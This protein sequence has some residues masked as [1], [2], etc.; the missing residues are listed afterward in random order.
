M[1]TAL[2]TMVKILKLERDQGG[3]DTAVMGGLGA[4][5]AGWE[6][7]ARQQARNPMHHILL[8]EIVDSL[9]NYASLDEDKSRLARVTYLLDRIHN[10]AQPP[11]KYRERLAR[12]SARLG[13][14]E[15][16]GSGRPDRRGEG[17]HNDRRQAKTSRGRRDRLPGKPAFGDED[18]TWENDYRSA[19]AV[20]ELDL[21]P[22]PSLERPPRLPRKDWSL[23]EAQDMTKR[24][25]APTTNVRGIGPKLSATLENLGLRTVGD[26]LRYFPRAYHD[27][28]SFT[29]IRDL[30]AGED[31]NVIATVRSCAVVAGA[32]GREDFVATVSDGSGALAL[33]FF[34]GGW[35]EYKLRRGMQIELH[36]RTSIYRDRLQMTNPKWDELDL[37]N[38][39]RRGLTPVYRLTEGLRERS[40]RNIMKSLS[41]D[42]MENMPD[43]LPLEAL[44]RADL[45]D[46]GWALR[47][48]HFP[49]GWDH[50][51]HARRRLRFDE[52]VLLQ[53]A[54]LTKRKQWQSVTGNPL[55]VDDDALEAFIGGAFDFELTSAQKKAI[56][57]IRADMAQGIPMSRLLQGDVGSGKTAVAFVA[58]ALALFNAKQ[59]A[60]MAPTGI[61]AE[62]H[63]AKMR[64]AFAD[65]PGERQPVIALLTGA[66]STTERESIYRRIADGSIDLVVGTH[67]LIQESLEFHDLG[68]AV[69]DEQQRF[70]VEQRASLRGKGRNPHLLIMTATPI[71]RTLAQTI[72]ADLDLTLIDEMPPGRSPVITR[73]FD[74]IARERMHGFVLGQIEA[75]RQVFFA[76]PLVEESESIATASAE[77]AHIRLRKVFHRHR[78]CLLHGRMTATEKDD[79]MDAFRRGD[80]DVMVTT[81]VTEVGVDVPN[82][83][84]MVVD[85]ANRFG[86]AQLHQFRGRVGR[87]EHQSHCFLIPDKSENISVDRV[88]DALDGVLP[89]DALSIAEQRLAAMA[90]TNDGFE[91]AELDWKLRGGGDILG[92]KQSGAN[93]SEALQMAA[94]DLVEL[95]QRE[96]RTL[97][98]EDPD[99]SATAHRLLKARVEAKY[100]SKTVL[101]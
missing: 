1:P 88:L 94:P 86:L 75:G 8:D 17:R 29:C 45:A 66:L 54:M 28:T 89:N 71:P 64:E 56:A 96:A 42:W 30:V 14:A 25:D 63:Y 33:R 100:P 4:F 57:A 10:R 6:A 43:P 80:Y 67:A 23:Q 97:F 19:S 2:E 22:L 60:L 99:L 87:G 21:R 51:T 58:L 68:V 49:D 52:L 92:S 47:Q 69:I 44:E 16:R 53:L 46:L 77:E 73:I 72:H 3:R 85:G 82:A 13:D 74:P 31:A 76:H 62:Q 70:G 9:A 18:S 15:K 36:G 83:T 90:R 38:L 48:A 78:V 40:F 93:V 34:H 79:L 5:C 26:L 35:M 98:D 50:L 41:A 12:S 65:F 95:A 55:K 11:T 91:L 61:L 32:G 27:Y 20:S 37:E 59:A 24:L 7:D 81:S 39:R 101:S 84:V